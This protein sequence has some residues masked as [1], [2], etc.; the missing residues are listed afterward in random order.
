MKEN[1]YLSQDGILKRKHNTVYFVNKDVE[2]ILPVDQVHSVYCYGRVSFSSGVVAYLSKK[3]VP[4]HFF[5]KYGFY[6]SSLYPRETLVSGDVVIHQA[7]HYL[8]AEKRLFLAKSFVRGSGV[9][10]QKNLRY[11]KRKSDLQEIILSLDDLL[12][13]LGS[14]SS[15]GE[16]MNVE[17]R[18]WNTYYGAYEEILPD[19]FS[20]KKR[21][22]RPPENMVNCLISFGNSILYSLILSEVYNT[23]LNPTISFLHEPFS[24][25]F[26]LALDFAEVFKPL[27]VDRVN[28]KLL[29]KGMLDESCFDKDLNSCLLNDKGRRIYLREWDDKLHTTIR[30][31]KLGRKVS[32]RRLT[33]LECY[34]L[35]K[36]VL[37]DKKYTPFTIWW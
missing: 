15:V 31:R 1:Y 21:T 13:G 29:N 33:R 32:Y 12:E 4:L 2:Q 18:V 30:H 36:H 6:E 7:G 26:S 23:Q 37:G 17:G 24:R 20:F 28:F 35:V 14:C 3:G 27:L 11:Y 22:R 9:N 34:K 8:D 19:R 25:R 10:I 5:N 16:V